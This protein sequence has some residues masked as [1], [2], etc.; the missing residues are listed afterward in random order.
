[1]W[2]PEIRVIEDGTEPRLGYPRR[3]ARG[4]RRR[5]GSRHVIRHVAPISLRVG[6]VRLVA[7]I[8]I[9][10]RIPGG[11]IAAYMA[12]R[13]GIH[14]GPDGAGNGRAWWQHVRPLQRKARG[15]VVKLSVRPKNCVVARGAKRS[16]KIRG[17][18][19]WHIP[20]KR[21]RA[22]PGRLVAAV[23]IRIRRGEVV[24]VPDMAVR[25]GVHLARRSQLV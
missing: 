14:H 23:A 10:G 13:A 22:V 19:V 12:V 16:R 11:V 2:N 8:T 17:D 5:V 15:A 9:R 1:M 3:M 18:V 7:A 4:A 20:A 25:A 21:R 24:I 6:V